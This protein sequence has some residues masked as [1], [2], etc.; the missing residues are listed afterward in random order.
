[1]ELAQDN[2]WKIGYL[3]YLRNG[4][5]IMKSLNAGFRYCQGPQ[6]HYLK[7]QIGEV[8]LG[9]QEVQIVR[10]R[11]ILRRHISS[12]FPKRL[13]T[14]QQRHRS[15]YQNCETPSY[16]S[17]SLSMCLWWVSAHFIHQTCFPDLQLHRASTSLQEQARSDSASHILERT[18]SFI[19]IAQFWLLSRVPELSVSPSRLNWH[20]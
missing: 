12:S 16:W 10:S 18:F 11:G 8:I 19:S 2:F 15:P 9:G 4:T 17:V 5:W 6:L 13:L 7:Y 14:L 1:M 20:S 3:I